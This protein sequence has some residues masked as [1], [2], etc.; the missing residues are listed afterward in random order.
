MIIDK[1]TVGVTKDE[2]G[3]YVWEGDII[4]VD[5]NIEFLIPL[6]KKRGNK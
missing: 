4:E 3:R 6:F 2:Y 5:G 1:N